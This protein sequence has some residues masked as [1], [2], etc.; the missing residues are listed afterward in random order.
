[1]NTSRELG[2]D[3]DITA[4]LERGKM[5]GLFEK[6]VSSWRFQK[7]AQVLWKHVYGRDAVPYEIVKK[8]MSTIGWA[9]EMATRWNVEVEEV[10]QS[11]TEEVVVPE[12]APQASQ[13]RKFQ[14]AMRWTK[15]GM[16]AIMALLQ[17]EKRGD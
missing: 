14:F 6:V 16:N 7:Y 5:F 15:R 4:L 13:K 1:V 2:L 11:V 8:R 9:R 17:S 10:G 3:M 12:A